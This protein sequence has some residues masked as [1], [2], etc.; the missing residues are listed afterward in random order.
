MKKI[1]RYLSVS[2]GLVA[3]FCAF[4]SQTANAATVKL[5]PQHLYRWAH[6]NNT[7]RLE[8][9]KRYINLMDENKNTALCLAQQAKDKKAYS[10]LLDYGASTKAP[11]HDDDDP[12]CAI[13]AG[14]KTKVHPA[15]WA[16]L[17]AGAAAGAYLLI[18]DDDGGHKCDITQ[19]PLPDCPPHGIC[20]DC[21]GKKKLDDCEEN[22]EPNADR[23]QCLPIPCPAGEYTSCADKSGYITN[24]TPTG[25]FSGDMQCYTC[26]YQCDTTAGFYDTDAAC[27]M[28]YT[29]YICI[30]DPNGCYVKGFCDT[31]KGHYTTRE[32]CENKNPGYNCTPSGVDDGCWTKDGNNP[33][34]CTPPAVKKGTC[35]KPSSGIILIETETN[36]QSG[37]TKC[38]NC[39]YACDTANGWTDTCPTGKIC[40][41]TTKPDGSKCYTN[42]QCPTGYS[43]ANKEECERA[44]P[45]FYCTENINSSGCWGKDN[46]N[47]KQCT[48]PAVEAGKCPLPDTYH[49]VKEIENGEQAGNIK[50]VTCTYGCKTNYYSTEADCQTGGYICT[51]HTQQGITCWEHTSDAECPSSHPS[52]TECIRNDAQYVTTEDAIDNGDGKCYKCIYTCKNG[53]NICPAGKTCTPVTTPDGTIC[54]QNPVCQT[55]STYYASKT[56][57]ETANPG[58]TCAENATGSLCWIKTAKQCELPSVEKGKCDPAGTGYSLTE[59]ETGEQAGSVKCVECEYACAAPYSY[60]SETACT[61]G[62]YTCS[63]VTNHG[64]SCWKRDGSADCP[65]TH[66]NESCEKGTGYITTEDPLKVGDKICYNCTYACDTANGYLNTCPAGKTCTPVTTPAG[67]CQ[68]N[69]VCQTG[70][71][72]YANKTACETANPGYTCAENATGSLCWIKTAKQCERPSVEKGKCDPAAAGRRLIETETGEQAGS[73]KCVNC[74]YE[75]DTTN[76]Y[77]GTCPTYANTIVTSTPTTGN[78]IT[79]YTC[80]YACDTSKGYY[81]SQSTCQTTT[82]KNCTSTNTGIKTCWVAGDCPSGTTYYENKSACETANKGYTC[83]ENVTGSKCWIKT[84]LQCVAPAST[85]ITSTK[86][87]GDQGSNGWD[88]KQATDVPFAAGLPCNYCVKKQCATGTSTSYASSANCPQYTSLT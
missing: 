29:G 3:A 77:Y 72:Y 47:P 75:C 49:T 34:Q 81:D 66:P 45:G 38:V 39:T 9:F 18:D 13:I 71:T 21:D 8:Q 12:I 42:P 4:N 14:E 24:Q 20:S 26:A 78:S 80:S 2:L 52:K 32:D 62:G 17:A 63:K 76:N 64:F 41:E 40:T 67:I 10:L 28:Q 61:T 6:D 68:T 86:D 48:P 23:T 87:C 79:C 36:E 31:T 56:A 69:P 51:P 84:A 85:S 19:Y 55:G 73:V 74:S 37:D 59:R 7:S 22:W 46:S 53:E 88:I 27:R 82:G 54:Y 57:C 83:A 15:A 50:C 43:Y 30:Q 60:T 58:Y 33:K 11:C 70:S 44:N 65:S 1:I 35:Q 5:R 25:H 16:L